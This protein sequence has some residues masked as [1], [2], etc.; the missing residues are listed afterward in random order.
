[1][2]SQEAPLVRWTSSTNDMIDRIRNSPFRSEYDDDFCR[3]VQFHS[4]AFELTCGASSK[5]VSSPSSAMTPTNSSGRI[6]DEFKLQCWHNSMNSIMGA[7]IV[8]SP[9]AAADKSAQG[10]WDFR[11]DSQAL[12]RMMY[13]SSIVYLHDLNNA[14]ATSKEPGTSQGTLAGDIGLVVDPSRVDSDPTDMLDSAQKVA[15]IFISFSE[16]YIPAIPTIFFIRLIHSIVVL[17]QHSGSSRVDSPRRDSTMDFLTNGFEDDATTTL[18]V[19]NLIDDLI[20]KMANGSAYWPSHKV[21]QVLNRLRRQLREKRRRS[22]APTSAPTPS[23]AFAPV[24]TSQAIPQSPEY[25]NLMSMCTF[26]PLTSTDTWA[27]S[28]GDSDQLHG[29]YDPFATLNPGSFD[30]MQPTD[31]YISPFESIGDGDAVFLSAMNV[32]PSAYLF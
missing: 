5:R 20:D 14:N 12:L 13:H 7:G 8:S 25:P 29:I 32:N 18:E 11:A 10:R 31:G 15:S 21:I 30:Q 19:E 27:P 17:T 16:Q 23:A 22:V 4:T 26:P 6:V 1:M 28:L 3:L 2:T 24:Q 9:S